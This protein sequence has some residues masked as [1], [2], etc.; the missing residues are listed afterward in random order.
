[1]DSGTYEANSYQYSSSEPYASTQRY[2]FENYNLGYGQNSMTSN[3]FCE[4]CGSRDH[5]KTGCHATL[6]EIIAWNSYSSNQSWVT[7]PH[8]PFQAKSHQSITT[9]EFDDFIMRH[10]REV[11]M[12]LALFPPIMDVFNPLLT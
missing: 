8:T 5:D 1:M 12:I 2:D 3:L 4:S 10:D 11:D 9:N 6:G 7:T